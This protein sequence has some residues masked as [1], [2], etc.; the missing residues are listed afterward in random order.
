MAIKIIKIAFNLHKTKVLCVTE[1]NAEEILQYILQT[2]VI[3]EFMKIKDALL[4]G[5]QNKKIYTKVQTTQSIYEMR[6]TN[7][8]RNDRIYCRHITKNNILYIIMEKLYTKKTQKIPKS[9]LIQLKNIDK[10]E[11]DI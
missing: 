3:A 7:K 1:S 10:Y 6:F 8:K 2:Q 11:Y 4:Q 5:I 9:V